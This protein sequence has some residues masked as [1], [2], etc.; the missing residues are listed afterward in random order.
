MRFDA[1]LWEVVSLWLIVSFEHREDVVTPTYV[2]RR[3]VDG[4]TTVQ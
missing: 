4:A 3:H 2:V 1:N